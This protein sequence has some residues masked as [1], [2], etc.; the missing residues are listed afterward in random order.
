M[1][2]IAGTGASTAFGRPRPLRLI[3]VAMVVTDVGFVVYWAVVALALLPPELAYT[4]YTDPRVVAWNWSFL[5]IDLVISATGLTSLA[6]LHRAHRAW[7]GLMVVSLTLTSASGMLA[8]SY[9]AVR[10][11]FDPAWWGPN[12]FLLLYPV[13]ALVW[14]LREPARG[15]GR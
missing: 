3:E 8:V 7:R 2:T 6:L 14:L 5:P 4:D 1:S 13:P 12:L 9:W 10:G 11:E 15:R